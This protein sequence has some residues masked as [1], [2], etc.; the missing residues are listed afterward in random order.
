M[1]LESSKILRLSSFKI[2]HRV[3][4][5]VGTAAKKQTPKI[6]ANNSP[7]ELLGQISRAMR[8]EIEPTHVKVNSVE[9]F[10]QVDQQKVQNFL[11]QL[12]PKLAPEKLAKAILS[13][14]QKAE[15]AST[16]LPPEA[17][18]AALGSIVINLANPALMTI[19][20]EVLSKLAQAANHPIAEKASQQLV[21]IQQHREATARNNL[22]FVLF[23]G[24]NQHRVA[25]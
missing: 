10:T 13:N 20:F 9:R 24:N 4:L 19:S 14:S 15:S 22:L 25:A 7:R 5:P 21:R 17:I 8:T 2:G 6:R 11:E 12:L 18:V 16:E 3:R 23:T 1:A